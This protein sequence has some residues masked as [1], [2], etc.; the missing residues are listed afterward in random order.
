M[1][2]LVEK[3]FRRWGADMVLQ[4]AGEAFNLRGMIH[5]SGSKSWR[6]MEKQFTLLGEVPGGQYV[7]IGPVQPA[8]AAGDTLVSGG[9]AYELRR[10]ERVYLGNVPLYCWG[11]CVEKGVEPVWAKRS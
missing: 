3:V 10:V 5:Y 9:K 6:N 7:Y 1:R 2:R 11:L 4:Q 8:A